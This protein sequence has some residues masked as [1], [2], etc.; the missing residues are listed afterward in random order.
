MA[1]LRP[2]GLVDNPVGVFLVALDGDK[3]P[4]PFAKNQDVPNEATDIL[5]VTLNLARQIHQH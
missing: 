1:E 4:I 5:L 2:L 3:P